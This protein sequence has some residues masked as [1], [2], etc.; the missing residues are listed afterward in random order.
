MTTTARGIVVDR[1]GGPEVLAV[2]E[3][4]LPAPAAG[5]ALVRQ[6]MIGVNFTDVYQ[7]RGFD[8]IPMP[9]TPG[10]EASGVVEAV[11]PGVSEV[12]PGDRV[13]YARWRGSY[14]EAAVVPV[15]S[16]IPLP[17]EVSFEQGAAFGMQGI[18]AQYL[19]TEF[20]RPVPGDT[21][22]VHA[23]AGGVGLMLVQFAKRFGASVIGTVSSPH[24]AAAVREAGGDEVIDYTALDFADEVLRLTGGRGV[25]LVLDGVGK[26]TFEG[27]LHALATQGRLVIYGM[28]SGPGEPLTPGMLIGGSRSV[29]GGDI[30]DG[31]GTRE[32]LLSRA[33][34]VLDGIGEGWLVPRVHAVL[35]LTEAAEAHRMLED[36]GTIGKVLLSARG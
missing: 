11:G 33:T 24:K 13:A 4:E 15:S 6:E 10:M 22:L 2:Q 23:A 16:L 12:E 18:T 3:I 31:I 5:E 19:I 36:R 25:D 1:T 8:P 34:E 20:R 26:A 27:S 29:S 7:R 32:E 9:F 30:A 28:A 21:V 17:D 35:P 14:A